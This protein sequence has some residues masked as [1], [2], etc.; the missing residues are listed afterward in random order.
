MDIRFKNEETTIILLGGDSTN[1]FAR[2]TSCDYKKEKPTPF[3]NSFR[4]QTLSSTSESD[5]KR[6]NYFH[7]CQKRVGFRLFDTVNQ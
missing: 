1:C 6:Q 7:L 5:Q 4:R 3:L 2:N